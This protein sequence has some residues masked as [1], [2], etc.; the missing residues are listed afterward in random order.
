MSNFLEL[1]HIPIIRVL[2][3]FGLNAELQPLSLDQ[4]GNKTTLNYGDIHLS[5]HKKSSDAFPLLHDYGP[6]V[7]QWVSNQS[8]LLY[9]LPAYEV[10][11]QALK[12]DDYK[13]AKYLSENAHS[14]NKNFFVHF[15]LN[16]EGQKL[17]SKTETLLQCMPVDLINEGV[18]L[19]HN[20]Y[21]LFDFM[22]C[23]KY[24]QNLLFLNQQSLFKRFNPLILLEQAHIDV[25]FSQTLFAKLLFS[26]V[27][28]ILL[29]AD[30]FYWLR[31]LDD[32]SF[33]V[34]FFPLLEMNT[35]DILAFVK[36]VPTCLVLFALFPTGRSWLGLPDTLTNA[37]EDPLG[38]YFNLS[39]VDG[40]F[41]DQSIAWWMVNDYS[42]I[43]L[44]EN[45]YAHQLLVTPD[46]KRKLA[47]FG[48]KGKQLL[49]NASR[50]RPQT[51]LT[52]RL[53]KFSFYGLQPSEG[54]SSEKR[55]SGTTLGHS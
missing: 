18:T 5:L 36:K 2:F 8:E 27:G 3:K 12:W 33:Q 34:L 39:I 16:H 14:L 15:L 24:G 6:F 41:K 20:H 22:A 9:R 48:D 55:M 53:S 4:Y 13:L 1:A 21:T 35:L 29:L 11:R 40:Y 7:N 52:A 32:E 42:G 26:E 54:M 45:H 23:D 51:D 28:R 10:G 25:T 50:L 31:Q 49:R 43:T 47:L 38:K 44:L 37:D 17:L 19:D 30:N 46:I